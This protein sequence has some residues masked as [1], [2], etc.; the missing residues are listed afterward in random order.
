MIFDG[1][2][3][4]VYSEDVNI[5]NNANQNNFADYKDANDSRDGDIGR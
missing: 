2:G 5:A 4:S 1:N 3:K